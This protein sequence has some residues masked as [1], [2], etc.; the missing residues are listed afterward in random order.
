MKMDLSIDQGGSFL[1]NKQLKSYYPSSSLGLQY[2]Y[3]INLLLN[4]LT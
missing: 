1:F 3:I 4:L 2:T